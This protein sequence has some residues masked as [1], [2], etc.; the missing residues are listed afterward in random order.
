[1]F[2]FDILVKDIYK[3][4]SRSVNKLLDLK[5]WFEIK[6]LKYHKVLKIYDIRWISKFNSVNNLYKN[7]PGVISILI[8][9][10]EN[11]EEI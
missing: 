10:K 1:M 11:A 6:K 5:N 3:Y 7:I 8:K 9:H 2:E 4:F